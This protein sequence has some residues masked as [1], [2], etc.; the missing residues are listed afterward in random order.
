MSERA[1]R[2]VRWCLLTG[3][4]LLLVGFGALAALTRLAPAAGF[5]T[6]IIRGASMEPGIPLGALVLAGRVE[7]SDVRR[8][9]VV[10]LRLPS[11]VIVTHR[12]VRLVDLPDGRYLETRGDA[13]EASDPALVPATAVVGVVDWYLPG[14]GFALALMAL[15]SGLLSTSSFVGTLLLAGWLLSDEEEQEEGA[16]E[17]SRELNATPA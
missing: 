5:E 9:D 12:A 8:D 16:D 7:P 4:A 1:I 11:G 6:F 3:A 13:N 17:L 15:P 10:T 14:A 2:L